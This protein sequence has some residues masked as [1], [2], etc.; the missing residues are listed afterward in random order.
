[1]VLPSAWDYASDQ[2]FIETP[3]L[4]IHD[5]YRSMA[6]LVGGGLMVITALTRLLRLSWTD[7]LF[8]VVVVLA[9][10]AVLHFA[11]PVLKG[12]GNWNLV[13]FFVLLLGAGVLLSVPIGFA[14]GLATLA[15]LATLTHTPLTVVVSRMDPAWMRA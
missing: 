13:L 8:G 2:W 11:A 12:L 10:M 5:T 6:I 3:A 14:F 1:M 9:M 4:G 15:Y 7:A